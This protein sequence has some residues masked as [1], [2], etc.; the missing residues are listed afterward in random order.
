MLAGFTER[1]RTQAQFKDRK[2]QERKKGI[3]SSLTPNPVAV[4]F[5]SRLS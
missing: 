2:V 5:F 1:V 3:R 4:R